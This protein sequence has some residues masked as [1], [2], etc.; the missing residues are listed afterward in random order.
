MS[1]IADLNKH[2][3][4]RLDIVTSGLMYSHKVGQKTYLRD[5]N[6]TEEVVTKIELANKAAYWIYVKDSQGEERVR[7]L[8]PFTMAIAVYGIEDEE[9]SAC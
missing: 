6:D 9:V 2:T 1:E 8:V 7:Y 3:I 5:D 4:I